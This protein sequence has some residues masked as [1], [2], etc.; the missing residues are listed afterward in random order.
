MLAV[1]AAQ[2]LVETPPVSQ[3]AM[4]TTMAA[5]KPTVSHWL[6]LIWSR[7]HRSILNRQ[8]YQYRSDNIES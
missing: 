8:D 3:W 1:V 4:E 7:I 6:R 5:H 2:A